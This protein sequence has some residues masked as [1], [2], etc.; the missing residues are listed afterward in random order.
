MRIVIDLAG[1]KLSLFDADG[2]MIYQRPVST[3]QRGAGEKKGS[4]QTPRG[5]HFIRAKIGAGAPSGAVFVGRRPTGEICRNDL[6]QQHPERD[7]IL[8]RVLWLSGCQPGFNRLGDCDTMARYIYIH[9]VPDEEPIGVP[10]SHGCIRMRNADVIDL[11]D[12][13]AVST[14]V[15]ILPEGADNPSTFPLIQIDW[16]KGGI[17]LS[18]VRRTVF[19]EEQGVPEEIVFD[20]ADAAAIHFMIWDW[21]GQPVASAR[22]LPEGMVGRMAVVQQWRSQGLGD[23]LLYAAIIEARRQGLQELHTT[24][25]ASAAG[26]YAQAGFEPLGD[27]FFISGIERRMMRLLL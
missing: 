1:Q 8:S 21:Q 12:R 16:R 18:S 23:R 10:S 5:R 2:G 7:W 27:P 13:V 17:A 22:L 19:I 26:F 20:A 24:A 6:I 11:F 15:L 25:R 9:G 3:A 4:F 14:E